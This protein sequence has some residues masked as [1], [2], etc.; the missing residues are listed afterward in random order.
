MSRQFFSCLAVGIIVS[1]FVACGGDD[2]EDDGPSTQTSSTS[3]SG[4]SGGSTGTST[5]RAPTGSGGT[6]AT[7][8]TRGTTT[9]GT[10]GSTASGVGGSAGMGMG[11]AAGGGGEGGM[12][13]AAALTD[14][15][16]LHA[17]R[18]ANLGEVEQAQVALLRA[19]DPLVVDF[20]EMMVDEHSEAVTAAQA[21]ADEEDLTPES[22]IVS[23]AV[24][25]QSA[26]IISMLEAASDEEFDRVYMEAQ[27][28]VHEEVLT[29]LDDTLIPQADNAALESYLSGLEM[30]VSEHLEAAESIVE[31]LE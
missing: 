23:Q 4:G 6:E 12:A 30:H 8:T 24:Q 5:T 16:I 9:Q 3:A 14:E 7:S 13:G 21:L 22:N 31:T 17:A 25:F 2:D 18:T 29:L 26:Q 19:D 1:G 27:V 20:A 11:G 15:E 28:M 10:G